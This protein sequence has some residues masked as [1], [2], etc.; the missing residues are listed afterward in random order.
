MP[1]HSKDYYL[2][3]TGM[4][5]Q[6]EICYVRKAVYDSQSWNFNPDTM[7]HLDGT[8]ATP[9]SVINVRYFG[10]AGNVSSTGAQLNV[11]QSLSFRME[12]ILDKFDV[13][14]KYGTGAGNYWY[15]VGTCHDKGNPYKVTYYFQYIDIID[16]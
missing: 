13:I 4:N 16:Y 10:C 12:D 14:G 8:Y 9:R 11:R 7:S 1:F 5:T 15:F 3:F 6:F 2:K